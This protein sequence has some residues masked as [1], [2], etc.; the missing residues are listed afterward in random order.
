MQDFSDVRPCQIIV[1]DISDKCSLLYTEDGHTLF[2]AT[3][4]PTS[5]LTC[6]YT[7]EAYKHSLYI[8]IAKLR[9]YLPHITTWHGA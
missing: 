3:S 2:S 4:V 6:C 5:Q 1:T 8:F 9:I 7:P